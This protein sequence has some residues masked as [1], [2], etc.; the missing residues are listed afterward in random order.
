MNVIEQYRV[1]DVH[2]KYYNSWFM[3]KVPRKIWRKDSK[4]KLK[5]C[6]QEVSAVQEY[7]DVDLH[8]TA[9][10]KR[11][12]SRLLTEDEVSGVVRKLKWV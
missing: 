9:H 2:D 6:M 10:K 11:D 7:S 4:Y 3:S 5:V 8:N 1:V 12:I